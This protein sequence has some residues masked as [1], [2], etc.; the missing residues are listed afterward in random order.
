MN[1]ELIIMKMQ[2][3]ARVL[4]TVMKVLYI[5]TVISVILGALGLVSMYAMRDSMLELITDPMV[6]QT[7]DVQLTIDLL[8]A[9][10]LTTVVLTS[11]FTLLSGAGSFI[12]LLFARRFFREISEERATL[13][14][15]DYAR[16]LRM[17][18]LAMLATAAVDLVF[19]WVVALN[20]NLSL[21]MEEG[22]GNDSTVFIAIVLLVASY[23][24]KYGA[25]LHELR[26]NEL[27]VE[28][29]QIGRGAS[30]SVNVDVKLSENA[31][32]TAEDAAKK[33]DD[34]TFEGF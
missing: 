26:E 24:W 15:T 18:S 25:M 28:Y 30:V 14:R 5:L 12:A 19:S 29:E 1:K 23:I 6:E 9:L 27:R 31:R 34:R 7:E 20:G 11:V 3:P 13:M 33:E 17:I 16:R 32:A 4:G 8:T 10:D 2:K 22:V 21:L